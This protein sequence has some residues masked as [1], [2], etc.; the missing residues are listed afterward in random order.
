LRFLLKSVLLIKG[1]F[2]VDGLL[3]KNCPPGETSIDLSRVFCIIPNIY[4]MHRIF[5]SKGGSFKTLE[6]LLNT[7]K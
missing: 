3:D 6:I 1:F 4:T 2:R 7:D 5:D